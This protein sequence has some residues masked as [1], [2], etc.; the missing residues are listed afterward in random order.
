[1]GNFVTGN[2]A[3]PPLKTDANP[4]QGLSSELDAADING[5]WSAAG[6]LRAALNAVTPFSYGALGN[7][8]NDDR[9]AIQAAINTGRAVYIPEGFTFKI[10][11]SL[12]APNSGQLFFGGG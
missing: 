9:A 2:T 1:M 6:D 7:N 12:Y 3:L 11:D 10:G 5:L 4:P 8:S